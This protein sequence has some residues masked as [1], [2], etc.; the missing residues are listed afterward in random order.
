MTTYKVLFK[1]EIDENKDQL[2]IGLKLAR[3]LKI[4]ET[5]ANLLFNGRTYAIKEGL[6]FDKARLVQKK[7]QSVGIITECVAE[8]I[9]LL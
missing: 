1:G 3:Y 6:E 4:P 5:K 2:Q 9:E 8:K 7:L